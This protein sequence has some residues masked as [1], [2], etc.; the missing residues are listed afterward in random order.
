MYPFIRSNK[1]VR[2]D[3]N[4]MEKSTIDIDYFKQ[5]EEQILD[6]S[7]WKSDKF[8]VYDHEAGTGKSRFTQ[9]CIGEMT[10]TKSHR[11]LYVQKFK[12]DNELVNTVERINKYAGEEVAGYYCSEIKREERKQLQGLQVLCVTHQL[13]YQ[14]CKGKNLELIKNRDILIIDELPQLVKEI[15]V[16]REDIA[17]FWSRFNRDGEGSGKELAQKLLDMLLERKE[18]KDKSIQYIDFTLDKYKNLRDLLIRTKDSRD[19]FNKDEQKLL[20]KFEILFNQGFFISQNKFISSE[21][22]V[23]LYKLK[24][25]IV[26]D[27]NGSFD[28]RYL[29]SSQFEIKIQPKQFDYKNTDLFHYKINTTKSQLKKTRDKFYQKLLSKIEWQNTNKILFVTDKDNEELLEKEIIK[30]LKVYGDNLEKIKKNYDKEISIDHFGN[31]IGKNNYR[32]YESIVLLKTPNYSYNSY[33]LE[34]SNLVGNPSDGT[35]I[36]PFQNKDIEKLRISILSGEFYQAIKRINRENKL[37]S[38]IYLFTDANDS[39]E[40]VRKQLTNVQYSAIE[41]ELKLKY[42]TNNRPKNQLNNLKEVLLRYKNTGVKEVNKK[43]I[44]EELNIEASN[45]SK[46]LKEVQ[47]FAKENN[48]IIDN[49]RKILFI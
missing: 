32:Q 1:N 28:Y 3:L 25:N 46:L 14:I 2:G 21:K 35:R 18:Q 16:T 10:R 11:V 31:L 24:N 19:T 41:M 44:R 42:N 23:E 34:Y 37:K 45:L 40:I 13:Y 22:G 33:V 49:G 29:L 36:E 26:L 6:V 7:K 9:K 30:H 38:K 5:L 48:I 27:A 43:A 15:Y 47:N 12:K 39:I 4:L 17:K 20:E 8:Y